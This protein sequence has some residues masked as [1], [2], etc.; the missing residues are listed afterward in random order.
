MVGF[1]EL[2][3]GGKGDTS[4]HT[5]Q[6]HTSP[7]HG[8][9]T[10]LQPQHKTT[11]ALQPHHSNTPHHNTGQQQQHTT[12]L[13]HPII[14]QGQHSTRSRRQQSTSTS[15]AQSSPGSIDL[16]VATAVCWSGVTG[17][18]WRLITGMM[19]VSGASCGSPALPHASTDNEKR[20]GL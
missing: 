11:T 7:Q 1:L 10:T 15:A 2:R 14:P 13:A 12:I 8:T 18:A 5:T 4:G 20:L 19:L 9:T 6:K 16:T 3:P 17:G